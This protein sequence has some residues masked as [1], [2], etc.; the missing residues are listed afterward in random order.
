MAL[1]KIQDGV[2]YFRWYR[3]L[4]QV[5]DPQIKLEIRLWMK[6]AGVGPG[7]MASSGA[8]VMFK[9]EYYEKLF[10]KKIKQRF[11]KYCCLCCDP[12]EHPAIS[13]VPMSPRSDCAFRKPAEGPLIALTRCIMYSTKCQI[14][15][16]KTAGTWS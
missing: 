5:R 16:P 1:D 10:Q 15:T 2:R 13:A 12:S 14:N 4:K 6:M 3:P 11:A 7:G 9:K 8:H